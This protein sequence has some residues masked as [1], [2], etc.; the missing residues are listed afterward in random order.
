MRVRL[1]IVTQDDLEQIQAFKNEMMEAHSSM[2][3]TCGL[4]AM[5]NINDWYQ[6]LLCYSDA[7][8][9][10]EDKSPETQYLIMDDEKLVGMLDIRHNLN[11]PILK[12]F[13][14]HIG[15]SVRPSERQ[16]G[17]AKEGLKL[18]RMEAKK[19]N[20]EKIMISCLVDNIASRK[21]ILAN[22][23]IFDRDVYVEER[24][25]TYSVFFIDV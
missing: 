24:D 21:T 6:K 5:D 16:K 9:C 20:I 8:T 1:K 4:Q 23:G 10:P 2:D 14:G 25:E 11:H 3:G 13:G 17:Y 18:A 7:A 15:Y 22:G 19:Y 12:L